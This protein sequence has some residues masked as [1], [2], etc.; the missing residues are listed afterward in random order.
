[1]SI[2]S[3]AGASCAANEIAAFIE[4][5]KEEYKDKPDVVDALDKVLAEA[6][7]IKESADAGWY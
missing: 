1:M 7:R 4:S 6:R 2:A 5:K 3:D